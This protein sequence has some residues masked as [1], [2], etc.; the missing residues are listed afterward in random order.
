MNYEIMA[1]LL[2]E[3]FKREQLIEEDWEAL[4]KELADFALFIFIYFCGVSS[5]NQFHSAFPIC[6]SRPRGHNQR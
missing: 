6:L 2:S 5:S 3:G 4:K 1:E